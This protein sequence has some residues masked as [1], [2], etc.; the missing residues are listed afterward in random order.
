MLIAF[1]R[2]HERRNS[3]CA[4]IP[5]GQPNNFWWRAVEKC[6]LA[7]IVVLRHDRIAVLARIVPHRG[8][9]GA[10]HSEKFNVGAAGEIG[11]EQYYESRAEIFVK[12]RLQPAVEAASLRS[13]SAANSSAARTSSLASAGKS[14]RT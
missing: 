4:A 7:K 5:N 1:L 9:R 6:A 12:Q 10:A 13:R 2:L 3:I 11:R 14:R 8:I